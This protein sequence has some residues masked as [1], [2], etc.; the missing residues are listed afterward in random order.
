MRD[1]NDLAVTVADRTHSK[2]APAAGV[3]RTDQ[4]GFTVQSIEESLHFWIDV[5]GFKLLGRDSFTGDFIEKMTNV[6]GTT[7]LQALIGAPGHTIE[8]LQCVAPDDRQIVKPR[9]VD[10]GSVHVAFFVD[11]IDT[12]IGRAAAIGWNALGPT[13][14][15]DHGALKGTQLAYVRG[16]DGVMVE[17]LESPNV[18]S[19][20]S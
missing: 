19:G 10:V 15:V 8:L 9:P 12:L 1:T 5:M 11:D 18:A 2:P 13:Q 17:L 20:A 14:M 7:L 3:F 16:P 6:P 4:T